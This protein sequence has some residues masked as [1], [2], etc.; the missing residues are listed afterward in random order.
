MRGDGD[1]QALEA[2]QE[3]AEQMGAR[4]LNAIEPPDLSELLGM[5]VFV[6]DAAAAHS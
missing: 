1:A 3:R 2:A 6:E 5:V 4:F